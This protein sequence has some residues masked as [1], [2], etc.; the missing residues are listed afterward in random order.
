MQITHATKETIKISESNKATLT[1]ELKVDKPFARFC[2]T[3]PVSATSLMA[4]GE[5]SMI[6]MIG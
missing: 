3:F 2:L 1:L 4:R 5:D 6:D